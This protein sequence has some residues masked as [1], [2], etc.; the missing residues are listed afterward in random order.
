[1]PIA[2]LP[3]ALPLEGAPDRVSVKVNCPFWLLVQ[4]GHAE[5]L[6]SSLSFSP[7]FSY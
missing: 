7:L 2:V 3:I 4:V 6:I 1:M 5:T